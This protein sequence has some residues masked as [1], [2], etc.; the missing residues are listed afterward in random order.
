MVVSGPLIRGCPLLMCSQKVTR[1][2][3][4]AYAGLGTWTHFGSPGVYPQEWLWLVG[5]LEVTFGAV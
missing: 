4:L 3:S 5:V 1:L 2:V